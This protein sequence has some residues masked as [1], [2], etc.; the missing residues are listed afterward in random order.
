MKYLLLIMF[1]MYCTLFLILNHASAI[2][3]IFINKRIYFNL[4]YCVFYFMLSHI[5]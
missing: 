2:E 5:I 1:D 4:L 3:V